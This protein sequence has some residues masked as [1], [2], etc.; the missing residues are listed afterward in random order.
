[1]K[2]IFGIWQCT[3]VDDC[4]P[5][6]KR[7]WRLRKSTKNRKKSQL[8]VRKFHEIH[9]KF[10]D[11]F[12]DPRGSNAARSK[13]S[14]ESR[15]IQRKMSFTTLL[16]SQASSLPD[17]SCWND[18]VTKKNT[19][20]LNPKRCLDL[21]MELSLSW[22]SEKSCDTFA[23]LWEGLSWFLSLVES[24]GI[25]EESNMHYLLTVFLNYLSND[26]FLKK[27]LGNAKFNITVDPL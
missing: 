14:W 10:K 19:A 20:S 7:S 25:E 23:K 3:A 27:N 18:F 26:V 11:I 21:K 9:R 17:L 6:G 5:I 22:P 15:N 1:M 16:I 8:F 13:K 2:Y 12:M 4:L 24:P